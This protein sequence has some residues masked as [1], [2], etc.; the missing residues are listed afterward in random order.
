VLEVDFQR[1]VRHAANMDQ[2]L[3]ETAEIQALG[4][5]TR[6]WIVDSQTCPLL[7]MHGIDS[8]GL[9]EASRGFRFVREKPETSVLMA[10]ITGHGRAYT[11]GKFKQFLPGMAYLMPPGVLHGYEAAGRG[12]WRICWV[13]HK[14]PKE[15]AP[16]ISSEQPRLVCAS[17]E[18]LEEAI[19]GLHRE[20]I[21]HA[22]APIQKLYVELIHE[23]SLRIAQSL[24]MDDR[25]WKLWTLAENDL[26][27][28]WTLKE[29]AQKSGMSIES[30]R[31]LSRQATGRSPMKQLTYLRMQQAAS[32]LASTNKKI[33]AIAQEVGYSDAFAFS[34]TFKRQIGV[35]PG[36]YRTRRRNVSI[37]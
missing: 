27:H 33:S 13:C 2:L 24:R 19:R 6:E 12:I 26:A 30:L 10:S 11:D 25:L 23:H 21:S 34:V 16:V 14:W 31:L 17:A 20:T 18:A 29:L 7:R 8:V 37:H 28:G 32:E 22:M 9:S 1:E 4:T 36:A 5:N 15:R 35:S 3:N